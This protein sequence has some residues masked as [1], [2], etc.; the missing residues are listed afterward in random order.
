M[1]VTPMTA[2]SAMPPH[3]GRTCVGISLERRRGTGIG[4]RQRLGAIGWSGQDQQCTDRSKSQ[5]FRHLHVYLRWGLSLRI[6]RRRAA[7]LA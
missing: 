2:S 5:K 1:P 4:Q 3:L 7:K 6:S